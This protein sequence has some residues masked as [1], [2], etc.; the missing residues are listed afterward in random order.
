MAIEIPEDKSRKNS[1]PRKALRVLVIEDNAVIAMFYA[2]LLVE[3]GHVV[4][5]IERT[6]ADAVVAAARYKPDL[7]IVDA[8]LREGSGVAAVKTILQTGFVPH[9]F[10]SGD[11]FAVRESM[12]GAIVIQKPFR[13]PDLAQAVQRALSAIA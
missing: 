4:C 2:D 11:S 13:D 7:M 8:A 6:E 10:V 1:T 12:P 9:V 5:A 3:I